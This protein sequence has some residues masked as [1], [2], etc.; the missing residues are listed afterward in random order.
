[1][2]TVTR[3]PRTKR[4][5]LPEA[6]T[7]GQ[8]HR[9]GGRHFESTTRTLASRHAGGCRAASIGDISYLGGSVASIAYERTPVRRG[10]A[11]GRGSV[12]PGTDAWRLAQ[13]LSRAR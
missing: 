7:F 10:S 11:V 3:P 9:P 8:P 13:L 5:L 12:A 4:V 2:G 6:Y 1:M